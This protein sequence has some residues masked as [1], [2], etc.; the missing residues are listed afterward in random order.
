MKLRGS[1]TVFISMILSVLIAFS[2]TVVDL[3]RFRAGEKLARAAVQMSVE[4]ALT[5]YFAPLRDNYGLW[6]SGYNTEELEAL[7]YDLL[8]KNLSVENAFMPGVTDL[9]GFSVE[10]V[11]VH[12]M[13]NLADENILEKEITQYMKYRAPVNTVGLFIEK[14]KA[15][16]MSMAQSGVLKKRMELEDEIQ[17]V[18]EKQVYLSMLLAERIPLYLK[19]VDRINDNLV[20]IS[21]LLSEINSAEEKNRELDKSY[22]AMPPLIGRIKDARIRIHGI[23]KEISDLEDEL[24]P[25]ERQYRQT[26]S[27][28]DSY[29]EEIEDMEREISKL[30]KKISEEEKKDDPDE[31]LI[32]SYNNEIDKL[33]GYIRRIERN[34]QSLNDELE[35]IYDDIKDIKQKISLRYEQIKSVEKSVESD[36]KQLRKEIDTCIKILGDIKRRA[37]TIKEK[38][39][40]IKDTVSIFAKYNEEGMKLVS[41]ILKQS[42]EITGLTEKINSD[43]AKQSEKS[44]NAFLVK[45]KADMKKLS[46]TVN[47]EVLGAIKSDLEQNY[48][49]LNEAGSMADY[50][51]RK[52]DEITDSIQVFINRTEQVYETLNFQE[53]EVFGPR[54][55]EHVNNVNEKVNL[56][57]SV[58]KM[59][60]YDLEP[61]VN[62]KEKNE[63][64]RWCN[65]VFSEK[66]ETG[67]K[68]K[69][70]EKKLRDNL[71][72][73][74]DKGKEESEKSFDGKDGKMPDKELDRLFSSLP[75]G[76]NNENGS[77]PVKEKSDEELEEQYKKQLD[78]NGDI[79]SR[80]EDALSDIGENL[81]KLLYINEYIICAF[82][83][84]NI[85]KVPTQSINI[86]GGPAKTFFEKAEVEYILFGKKKEKANAS[87]TQ[88]S[89]FGIRMGLNL[90]H[91]YMSTDKTSAAL[92]A[93]LSISGWTGFGVPIIKNLILI[94]W[95]AGESYVDLKD[96][97]EGKD[98][99]VYKTENTWKLNLKSIFTGIAGQFLDESSEWI[100]QTKDELVDKA[101]DAVKSLIRE[102]VSAAVHAAF[103]PVQKT[104]TEL[105]NESDTAGGIELIN[106]GSLSEINDMD[107]LKEWVQEFCLKQYQAIKDEASEWT[108]SKLEDYK[109]KLTDKIVDLIINSSAYKKIFSALKESLDNIIDAGANSLSESINQIGASIA[110]QGMQSQL[111]GT[112][113]SFN[114][115]DYLRLLLF[116]VPK[117]TKLLR[118]ADL[119]QLNMSETLD[120]PD[121]MLSE[122]NS[123]IV[124]EADI[125]MR[126]MF[127]PSFLK[128]TEPGRFKIRWGYGY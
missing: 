54:L 118:A 93:A 25:L 107:D 82:K 90:L 70:Y 69:G 30:E 16:N 84:A 56:T 55:K 125:Q 74:D 5:Q 46:L 123:F 119:I 24:V 121:F 98:V 50:S 65:K 127:I 60:S 26:E 102:M 99:P 53:R 108:E 114:Y 78:N 47:P 32:R 106:P 109:S 28:I 11:T 113:V 88:M 19:P 37:E 115:T 44:D 20:S 103:M 105:G 48:K 14:L 51:I 40:E 68:G 31:N 57:V 8:E 67:D 104:I 62:Q 12:P 1:V 120:N 7:I 35:E 97:N 95:A 22:H 45:I 71:K 124:V 77:S 80:I 87:L 100:K 116:T 79:A 38:M 36:E 111:V 33:N 126:A 6:A 122:Y 73:A 42:E 17:K 39:L 83:N 110:D 59:N 85:D 94:G 9:F 112:V 101:D 43:I 91:V 41:E 34:I 49:S 72:K 92:T 13:F 96:L 52:V 10:N 27:K 18:R 64:Y 21:S 128:R 2:G 117:K 89:I 15:L 29:Y 76:R 61:A 58:Y 81:L 63:F 23:E 86:Y 66:N 4:S 75:S 3:S